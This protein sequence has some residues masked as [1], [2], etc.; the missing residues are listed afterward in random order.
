VSPI[1]RLMEFLITRMMRWEI[2]VMYAR[3]VAVNG[4]E[5]S[6]TADIQQR[7]T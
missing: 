5:D 6:G 3:E 4:A 2:L 1:H 7:P